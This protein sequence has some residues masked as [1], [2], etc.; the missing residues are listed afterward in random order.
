VI[1]VPV[2][3]ILIV[4]ALG[5][6]MLLG[7]GTAHAAA[8]PA[9]TVAAREHFFGAENVAPDGSVRDDRV[10]LSWFSVASVAA[11]LDG[12]VLLLDAYIHKE[13]DAPNYVPATTEEL[14][15]LAPEAIF[16]GHGHFDHAAAGGE[17]IARAGAFLVGTPEPCDQAKQQAAEYT[18]HAVD[19]RCIDAVTRASEPGA[20]VNELR[21]FDD[22]IEVT[23]LKHLHSAAEAP[24]GENHETTLGNLPLPDPRLVLLHPPGPSVLSNLTTEGDEGSS[25][26]YQFRL[27]DFSLIWNDTAGPLRE[28]GPHLFEALSKLPPTDVELGSVLGFNDPTNGLRDIVDYV[29]RLK[30]TV[31]YPVH[32]DFVAEYGASQRMKGIMEREMARRGELPTELRWLYDPQDYLRPSLMTFDPEA[33]RWAGAGPSPE[34]TP[35]RCMREKLRVRPRG[36]GFVRIGA[37]PNR[38]GLRSATMGRTSRRLRFCVGEAESEFVTATHDRAGP[39]RLITTIA[40]QHR[41]RGVGVG[42]PL[43]TMKRRYRRAVVLGGGL[44]RA[45]PGSRIVFAARGARIRLIA[46]ADPKLVARPEKLKRYLRRA[47]GR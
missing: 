39:V 45:S 21:P 23:A 33:P 10:I 20:E 25:I 6:A 2:R 29:E 5:A 14:V 27:G 3:G 18:G 26:L 47:S 8:L 42:S 31:F 44:F 13:E 9:E 4:S 7:A 35:R 16:V 28:R 41:T 24:D 43:A 17:I 40:P 46:V 15:A 30:P 38:L 34:P 37:D 36:I 11:A 19:V 32:H 12:H 22:R 1:I